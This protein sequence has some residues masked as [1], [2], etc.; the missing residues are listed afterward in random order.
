MPWYHQGGRF[1]L[2][3]AVRSGV[4]GF[5]HWSCLQVRSSEL[6][7]RQITVLLTRCLS[8]FG[9]AIFFPLFTALLPLMVMPLLFLAPLPTC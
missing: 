1:L 6:W 3:A 5:G 4:A 8:S 2:L 7:D 9:A